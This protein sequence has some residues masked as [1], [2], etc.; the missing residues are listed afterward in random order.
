M[1]NLKVLPFSLKQ[2]SQKKKEIPKKQWR[3]IFFCSRL[4]LYWNVMTET[5]VCFH[6]LPGLSPMLPGFDPCGWCMRWFVVTGSG[7]WVSS[8]KQNNK[9]YPTCAIERESLKKFDLYFFF[10]K[11]NKSFKKLFEV[12]IFTL[13]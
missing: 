13:L 4:A 10:C 6:Q 2:Q 8:P 12:M 3:R 11:I 1:S 7:R 5:G 9:N